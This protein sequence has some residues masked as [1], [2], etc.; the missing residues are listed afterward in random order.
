MFELEL[1]ELLNNLKKTDEEYEM[2]NIKQ[3]ISNLISQ[4]HEKLEN[5]VAKNQ[6]DNNVLSILEE[7]SN[8]VTSQEKIEQS[9]SNSE[10]DNIKSFY[11]KWLDYY[12]KNNKVA[13]ENCENIVNQIINFYVLNR[14]RV[15]EKMLSI[16][17]TQDFEA[18]KNMINNHLRKYYAQKVELYMESDT[19]NS[20]GFF[21]KRKKKDKIIK[22]LDEIGEYKFR[23]EF[24]GEVLS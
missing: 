20:L 15:L 12:N 19:Y 3:S 18:F 9:E 6:L 10:F 11:S 4:N 16:K 13:E 17:D 24:I 5:F 22:L 14:Y 21:S 7:C 23:Q 2:K 1:L 8:N